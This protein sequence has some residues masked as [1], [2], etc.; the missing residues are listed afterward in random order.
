MVHG[1]MLKIVF[2]YENSNYDDK[3]SSDGDG[4]GDDNDDDF[5][6]CKS[7]LPV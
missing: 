5:D 7:D 3:I 1:E 2:S 6:D 4:D